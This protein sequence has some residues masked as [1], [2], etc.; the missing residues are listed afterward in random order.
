M[1]GVE[2][3][4]LPV[5]EC[6]DDEMLIES[7][8]HNQPNYFDGIV[9]RQISNLLPSK[10]HKQERKRLKTRFSTDYQEGNW[11]KFI[12][13]PDV[14]DP[15][16]RK[17][18]LFRR[19]FR[20]PFPVFAWI[21][22][23]CTHHNIFEVK[24]EASVEVPIPIK[25]M[26]CLRILGRGDCCDSISEFCGVSETHI[27]TIFLLFVKNFR[28][29]LEKEL[30]YAPHGQELEEI[31]RDYDML[32]LPG[33]VGSVDVTHCFLDK[34]PSIFTNLCTGKEK[35]PTL[36]FETV[37][38]HRKKIISISKGEYGSFNDKT[39][40]RMDTF[41]N[42]VMRGDLYSDIQTVY[43]TDG[44]RLAVK[45]VHLI[46]D[47]GYHK[48]PSMICPMSFRTDMKDV[49]WSEWIES[50]RKDVECTFGILKQRFRILKNPFQYHDLDTM[51]DVFVV[52]GMIHNI[53]LIVDGGANNWEAG[54]VDDCSHVGI[55]PKNDVQ[56]NDEEFDDDKLN[57]GING[58]EI[59]EHTSFLAHMTA[60]ENRSEW[61]TIHFDSV[62]IAKSIYRSSVS[63]QS[64]G[65]GLFAKVDIE[66][67]RIICRYQGD[68]TTKEDYE[69][70][71][72]SDLGGYC[73]LTNQNEYINCHKNAREGKCFASFAN[74]PVNLIGNPPQNAKREGMCLKSII[75]I[76]AGVEIL[77]SYGSAYKFP[78]EGTDRTVL[79]LD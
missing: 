9:A 13:D 61:T 78:N 10:P 31:M 67:D 52:C 2:G 62:Y 74:S 49:F 56:V 33:T 15:L 30:I 59:P 3:Q 12:T 11:G 29:H 5:D 44:T 77:T 57:E 22:T 8:I 20:V 6:S 45:G 38:T 25:V 43:N 14:K 73:L 79:A 7:F 70:V 42:D 17:G 27:R 50:V 32:G 60:Q 71:E 53:L 68:I 64:I 39:I 1:S 36:A 23:K 47:N 28:N 4:L 51:E 69:V 58:D 72:K 63:R 66:R 37:V 18:R 40:C 21:C 16:S 55:V 75:A 54:I 46:C 35:K 65:L 24:R 41:V 26:I 76:K 34:C 19:R 48:I